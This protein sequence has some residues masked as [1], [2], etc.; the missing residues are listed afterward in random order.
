MA[1]D[2]WPRGIGRPRQDRLTTDNM[3]PDERWKLL[4]AEFKDVCEWAILDC[5][6]TPG[7]GNTPRHILTYCRNLTPAIPDNPMQV[8]IHLQRFVKV[9]KLA[10]LGNWNGQPDSAVKA[11]QILILES[12]GF[13]QP[14]RVQQAAL[15]N[16]RQFILAGLGDPETMVYQPC[17]TIHL[18]RRV[19]TRVRGTSVSTATAVNLTYADDP[20]RRAEKIKHAWHVDARPVTGVQ[21]ED[22]KVVECNYIVIP[23]GDFVDVCVGTDRDEPPQRASTR[24]HR[25][26]I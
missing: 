10:P 12:H 23:P 21:R 9:C 15:N 11:A 26:H 25:L 5:E 6:D 18:R 20:L 7:N 13:D 1:R 19:F 2:H 8:V 4:G 14:F 17:D 24:H 3:P 16:I 22:G